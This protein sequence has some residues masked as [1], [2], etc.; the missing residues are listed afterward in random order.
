M[1]FNTQTTLFGLDQDPFKQYVYDPSNPDHQALLKA[2]AGGVRSNAKYCFRKC[3]NMS[4]TS[5]QVTFLGQGCI[6]HCLGNRLAVQEALLT[7]ERV[8]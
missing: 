1:D 2:Y 3:S 5:K 8:I 4:R 7:R 6:E